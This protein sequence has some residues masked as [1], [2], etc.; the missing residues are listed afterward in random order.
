MRMVLGAMV[1]MTAVCVLSSVP[2][3][4]DHYSR[5]VDKMWSKS[6]S[7]GCCSPGYDGEDPDHFAEQ[8]SKMLGSGKGWGPGKSWQGQGGSLGK[9]S[10]RDSFSGPVNGKLD[11]GYHAAQEKKDGRD[12]TGD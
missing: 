10:W 12:G 11:K 9:N 8:G 3:S 2:A 4:A 7:P 5:Q 1:G 6:E